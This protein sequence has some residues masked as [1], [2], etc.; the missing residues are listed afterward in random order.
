VLVVRVP[1]WP[2]GPDFATRPFVVGVDD[3]PA[4]TVAIVRPSCR[5]GGRPPWPRRFGW[6]T[7]GLGYPHDD[8]VCRLPGVR[9]RL[10]DSLDRGKGA[11]SDV[12][13]HRNSEQRLSCAGPTALGAK[14]VAGWN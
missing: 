14:Y 6:N 10:R 9:A 5:S 8:P 3:S 4:G 13:A 2:P 1:G 12:D 7:A 11:L